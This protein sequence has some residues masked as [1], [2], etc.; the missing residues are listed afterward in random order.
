MANYNGMA[1]NVDQ[2]IGALIRDLKSRG[3]LDDTLSGFG[4]TEFRAHADLPVAGGQKGAGTTLGSTARGW[5]VAESKGAHGLWV[6]WTR[7]AMTS[8][9]IPS[10]CMTSQ[11]NHLGPPLAWITSGLPTA[12]PDATSGSP[13]SMAMWSRTS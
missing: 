12:M 5:P 13:M 9:R 1:K 8:P 10:R 7:W 2:P 11:A 3:M 6:E 4:T